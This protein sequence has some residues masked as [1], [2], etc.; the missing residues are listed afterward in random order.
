MGSIASWNIRGLNNPKKQEDIAIF[1]KKHRIS[2]VCLLETKVKKEKEQ[3]IANHIFRNW[4]W[5]TNANNDS[6]GRIWVAWL[7][8]IYDVEIISVSDQLIHFLAKNQVTNQK[9]FLSAVYG[10]NDKD[11]RRRLWGELEEISFTIH[12]SWGVIGDFN[13]PLNLD[14]RQG[15]NPV[16]VAETEEFKDCTLRCELEEVKNEG[17]FFTWTNNTVRSRIDRFL[18]NEEW[19]S[20]GFCHLRFWPESISDHVA[21]VVTFH[22]TPINPPIFR[23]CDMWQKDRG[24]RNAIAQSM[25]LQ[26]QG[27]YMNHLQ[28]ILHRLRPLLRKLHKDSFHDIHKQVAIQRQR[29]EDIQEKL[30][31]NPE[32]IQII[33]EEKQQ[34]QEYITILH[35]SL[36]LMKQ[37]SNL[38]WLNLGDSSSKFFFAKMKQR[39]NSNYVYAIM[40]EMNSRVEGFQEVGRVMLSY[41]Q[42]LL[43]ENQRQRQKVKMQ[44][45]QQGPTL[46]LTQQADLCKDITDT[47]IKEAIFSIGTSKTP[48]P[49]GYSSGFFK[50]NWG[51]LGPIVCKAIKEFFRTGKLH[52]SWN[53]TNLVLIPKTI[54]PNTANEFRPIACCNVLYKCI[55][56]ILSE[57]LKMVLPDLV[58][59]CQGAFV[60]GRELLYNVLVC[61]EIA[62]G[63]TRAKISP[64]CML[65]VDLKKAYDSMRWDFIEDMLTSLKFPSIFIKWVMECITTTSYHVIVN[66]QSTGSFKGNKGLRQGD[67]ISPLLFVLGMEYLSRSLEFYTKKRG[68]E[69]HPNC[70]KL[71]LAHL[72]FADDLILFCKANMQSVNILMEA[73]EE[74]SLTSGMEANPHKSQIM[75][76]GCNEEEEVKI[77]KRTNFEAGGFPFKYLGV[78]ITANKLSKSECFLMIEKIA[79]RIKL[80]KS[81]SLSY[82]GR[83]RLIQSVIFGIFNFWAS[84]FLIPKGVTNTIITMCRDYLWGKEEGKHSMAHVSW[85]DLCLP[86]KYGGTG[87]KH[88]YLWNV[89][90]MGKLVWEVEN[91]KDVLW[92]KWIY[93]R[94]LKNTSWKDFT[95]P[96]DSCWYLKKICSVKEKMKARLYNAQEGYAGKYSV[97]GAYLQM[98]EVREEVS[99]HK[100]IWFNG[101]IPKHCF[102]WWLLMRRRLPVR[103]RLKKFMNIDNECSLCRKEN[104]TLEHMFL[105]C[106]FTKKVWGCISEW[107]HFECPANSAE[108]WAFSPHCSSVPRRARDRMA[109]AAAAVIYQ[110]WQERNMRTFQNKQHSA[111]QTGNQVKELVRNRIL[112]LATMYT[113][114]RKCIDFVGRS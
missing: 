113:K 59:Q 88:L 49:D 114:Y 47:Q 32:D 14:E 25:E 81:R 67:P 71:R 87:I 33:N 84:I 2:L 63:Y 74:F 106:D 45:I 34:R 62:R 94:Y 69:Y 26:F 46:S 86:R 98:F 10:A 95:P 51:V 7:P 112:Y 110:V 82:A 77:R 3:Q 72:M 8:N 61:Q 41:F 92:I 85:E 99:W 22:Q 44:I 35:S 60:R 103:D 48:G 105:F 68:F 20:L 36:A 66:G 38:H 83:L 73:F 19:H 6:K 43:G 102:I 29:L 90:L 109:I 108:E 11:D 12:D 57:R 75:I 30:H 31:E 40:N 58:N 23:Y 53:E 5:V 111:E 56:K 13:S 27:T 76:G 78:P 37:Q 79:G 70:R 97:Q 91:K 21:L 18:V 1:L 104:E 4:S 96:L 54:N 28:A 16:E 50:H 24:Y 15:G 101:C 65:K 42:K 80:W 64:R 52:P 107:L 100:I 93:A 39:K 17:P 89:A 55:S 9:F